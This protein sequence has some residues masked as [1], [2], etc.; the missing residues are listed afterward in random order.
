MMT[1]QGKNMYEHVFMNINVLLCFI[2]A[3]SFQNLYILVCD[4]QSYI[5]I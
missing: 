5:G 1:L 4:L 2:V 3:S